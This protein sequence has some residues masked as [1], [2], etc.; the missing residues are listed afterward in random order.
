MR[1]TVRRLIPSRLAI[2]RCDT[3]SAA[4]ALTSAQSNAL[5]T[6]LAASAISSLTI[7]RLPTRPATTGWRTFRFLEAAHYWA[8]GVSAGGSLEAMAEDEL[9]TEAFARWWRETGE[10]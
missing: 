6:S 1:L 4:I 7:S 8:P 9:T 3:P 5:R 10:H 2:S